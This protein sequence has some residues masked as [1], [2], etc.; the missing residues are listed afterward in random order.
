MDENLVEAYEHAGL[1]VRIE[2]DPMAHEINPRT[3][4]DNFGTMVCFHKRYDLGDKHDWKSDHYNGWDEVYKMLV[5][6]ADAAVIRPLYMFDH[7]GLTVSMGKTLF[8]QVDADGW[9]WGQ[10]GFIYITRQKLLAEFSRVRITDKLVERVVEI[11][12][13]EVETYDQYLRGEAYAF[14]VGDDDDD[15]LETCCGFYTVEHCKEE[16]ESTAEYIMAN[17]QKAAAQLLAAQ[18]AMPCCLP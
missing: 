11:F 7:G 3:E 15:C 17:R 8:Q 4:W 9:D 13:G 6:E 12:Q 16:A 1:K 18:A 14:M 10:I 5:D 2:Y